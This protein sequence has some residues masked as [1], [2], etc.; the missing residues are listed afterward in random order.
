MYST[1]FI[2]HLGNFCL[3]YWTNA[4]FLIKIF[5]YGIY[6]QFFRLFVFIMNTMELAQ[7][8]KIGLDEGKSHKERF[9]KF[10]YKDK[11]YLI[12]K[13]KIK[14]LAKLLNTKEEMLLVAV[15]SKDFLK[16]HNLSIFEFLD[17]ICVIQSLKLTKLKV[18]HQPQ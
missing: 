14:T 2:T 8:I 15:S 10:F 4:R 5:T 7:L 16:R 6:V 18:H 1:L 3:E 11:F 13:V 9:F 17:L 12:D